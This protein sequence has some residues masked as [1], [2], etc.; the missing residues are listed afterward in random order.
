MRMPRLFRSVGAAVLLVLAGA[1]SGANAVLAA[2]GPT[3]QPT[4]T[5]TAGV[6]PGG[7][8]S[9]ST[10]SCATALLKIINLDR[11]Q[12]GLPGLKLTKVQST[13]HGRCAG[14]YGHSRAMAQSGFIWHINPRYPRASFPNN[15]CLHY[16]TVGE[17]VGEASTGVALQDLRVLDKA[18]MSEPH[19]HSTCA[20]TV[21]HACNVLNP[22]FHQVGIGIYLA[23][24]TTWLTE[25][26]TN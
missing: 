20:A 4:P 5:A 22:N 1:P 11:A 2:E 12:Y 26:L 3:P 17:N 23:Q 18:M 24:G 13:G 25:D 10:A 14:S 7:C 16:T 8:S 6:A 9:G 15:I 21:N 19:Q